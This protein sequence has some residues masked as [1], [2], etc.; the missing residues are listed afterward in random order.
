[1]AGTNMPFQSVPF[2]IIGVFSVADTW[3]GSPLTLLPNQNANM[4]QTTN[5][6]MVFAYQ[7][8]SKQNNQGTL[9]LTSGGS[10]PDFLT[11]PALSNQ[12]EILVKNWQANNL[13]VTNVSP[14][15]SDTPILIQAI[16]PG[17][18]GVNPLDL[19]VGDPVNLAPGQTAQGN[20]LPRYMQLVLQASSGNL[21]TFALI[22][23]PPDQSGNNAYVFAVNSTQ[24]TGPGT[25]FTPPAG[26]YATTTSNY[27]TFQFNWGSSTIFVANM[28]GETAG[29]ATVSLR[30][31]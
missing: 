13:S 9:S 22:G 17:I 7:N 8:V 14:P 24:N 28:S 11:A 3:N 1:M 31:L 23:G 19:A 18:P 29:P 2:A 6:S 15:S 20:S 30:Q 27:T 25:G 4:P 5:G 12:P 16:G 26:Y 21:T 10:A